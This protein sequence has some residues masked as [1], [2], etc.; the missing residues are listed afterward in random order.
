[1]IFQIAAAYVMID[2]LNRKGYNV[3]SFSVPSLAEL[4]EITGIAAPVFVTMV[5]K[6]Y[7]YSNFTSNPSIF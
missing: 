1:M 6:V 4:Q 7:H 5:S 3:Y 2:G